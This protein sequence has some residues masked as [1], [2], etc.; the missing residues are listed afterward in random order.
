MTNYEMLKPNEQTKKE[1]NFV[2][3]LQGQTGVGFQA[4]THVHKDWLAT[5]H[6]Y[7]EGLEMLESQRSKRED[8]LAARQTLSPAVNSEGK[9]VLR[10][11]DGRQFTPTE[12]ALNQFGVHTYTST[13][14]LNSL[15]ENPVKPNGSLRFRRD[16]QDAETLVNVCDNALRRIDNSK[17]FRLRTYDDGTLRAFL[18]EKYA[19]IDNRWYLE[20]LKSSS[21]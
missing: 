9:F 5:T 17:V 1:G 13:F 8:I 11:Q 4:N 3:D 12:H 10:Y 18:T 7:D 16:K 19:P 6:S 20:L 2:Q 15:L 14:F 21:R